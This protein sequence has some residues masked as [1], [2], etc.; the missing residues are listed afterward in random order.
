[1][2]TGKGKNKVLLLFQEIRAPFLP[3]S[4][5]AVVLGSALGYR[6][7]GSFTW[8]LFWLSL[9]G[10]LFLHAGANVAND[11]FDHLSGND[12]ANESFVRPFT[13]GSRMI[14]NG[15]LKPGEVLALALSCLALGAAAGLWLFMVRGYE[16]LLLTAAGVLGGF[17]Y[18]APPVKLAHRGLGEA[19]VALNFG[20][21]PVTGARFVQ[22][23]DWSG[24][25][26]LL[27]VPVALLI[28]AVLFINEF[29]DCSA[30]AAVGKKTWVV[31]LGL[32]RASRVHAALMFAWF[33]P[34]VAGVV[35]G[36]L[37]QYALLSAL[38]FLPAVPAAVICLR[39]WNSPASLAPANALTIVTHLAAVLLLTLGV[40]LDIR[41][42]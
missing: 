14:Q 27:A 20:I 16:I 13:G 3:A 23:G 41:P 24:Q 6:A 5:A 39:K 30:D 15:L 31:R 26:L 22:A 9:A 17:F 42:V 2:K 4:L 37:P 28:A 7:S 34:V 21:L 29:Q 33:V 11:Y 8:D 18:V 10:V 35:A 40:L 19:L 12:E 36:L 38:A 25:S 1:M 32:R